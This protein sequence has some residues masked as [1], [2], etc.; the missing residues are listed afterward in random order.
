MLF[1]MN[2]PDL[3]NVGLLKGEAE[4]YLGVE[5]NGNAIGINKEESEETLKY[6]CIIAHRAR[7]EIELVSVQKGMKQH[8]KDNET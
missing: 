8:E 7:A 5:D 1:R 6:F 4:Y 2:Q 3:Y